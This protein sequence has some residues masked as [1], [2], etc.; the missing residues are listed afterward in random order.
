M[1]EVLNIEIESKSVRI[2]CNICSKT[3]W[4]KLDVLPKNTQM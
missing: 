2:L 1:I 4:I 3:S